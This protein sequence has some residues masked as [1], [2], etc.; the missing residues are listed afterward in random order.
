V[1]RLFAVLA[2]LLLGTAPK[3]RGVALDVK[4]EDIH[5]ILKSMQQ[6][7]AVK[8][9]IIDPGVSG[10]GTFYFHDVPCERAFDVVLRTMG[11]AAEVSHD[12]VA[13]ERRR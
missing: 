8:N 2:L 1:K 4:D 3:P 5:V 11:L 10:N 9:L 7:C 12:V 13:I 6:Q